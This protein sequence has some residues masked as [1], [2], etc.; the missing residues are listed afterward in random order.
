MI[1]P[2]VIRANPNEIKPMTVDQRKIPY[3]TKPIPNKNNNPA[4]LIIKKEPI[5]LSALNTL[6]NL[7]FITSKTKIITQYIFFHF[8]FK[9]VEHCL[10]KCC[11]NRHYCVNFFSVL[12]LVQNNIT[13]VIPFNKTVIYCHL[14]IRVSVV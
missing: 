9:F 1:S 10:R 11:Y 14:H 5:D 13:V 12:L 2:T 7:I 6:S 8:I 3:T 4:I